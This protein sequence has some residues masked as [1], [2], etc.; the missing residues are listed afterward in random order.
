MRYIKLSEKILDWEW[1][2]DGN[3]VKLWLYLLLKAQQF[4]NTRYRG[5][6]LKTGQL[7]TGRKQIAKE[8]GLSEREV[9]T[10]LERLKSTNEIAIKAT[11]KY[12]IVTLLK[13]DYYQSNEP[14]GVQ[15]N[16]QLVDQQSTNNRPTID[17]I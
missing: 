1:F 6:E 14:Y 12:S 4:E 13:Y 10:C 17:H 9:R 2:T 11:N 15:Q 3:M 16:D 5:I 7:V 8:T